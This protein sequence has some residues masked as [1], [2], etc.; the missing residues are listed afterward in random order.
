[1]KASSRF[2]LLNWYCAPVVAGLTAL[3]IWLFIGPWAVVLLGF[4]LGMHWLALNW[5]VALT[6]LALFVPLA[7]VAYRQARGVPRHHVVA[8]FGLG[9]LMPLAYAALA[10]RPMIR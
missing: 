10:L 9:A 7:V 2:N 3:V 1:M 6:P 4:G 5:L 8:G